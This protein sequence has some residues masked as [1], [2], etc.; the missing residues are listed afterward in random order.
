ML[1]VGGCENGADAQL[2]RAARRQALTPSA[3][4]LRGLHLSA[5]AV[6]AFCAK[7]VKMAA[8][9]PYGCAAC[10]FGLHFGCREWSYGCGDC[11]RGLHGPHV[12]RASAVVD[13][14]PAIQ[15]P[16]VS[17]P[18]LLNC[19]V[20]TYSVAAFGWRRCLGQCFCLLCLR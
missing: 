6:G 4:C 10:T 18:R 2:R 5:D 9:W 17:G 3:I 19:A 16:F 15:L 1:D 13:V 11:T 14:M 20:I 8:V 7:A 12:L